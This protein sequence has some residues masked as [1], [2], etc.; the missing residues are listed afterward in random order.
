MGLYHKTD[1]VG[2][3]ALSGVFA[4]SRSKV[5]LPVFSMSLV[6]VFALLGYPPRLS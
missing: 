2:D 3:G 4:N 5:C 1:I 6:V